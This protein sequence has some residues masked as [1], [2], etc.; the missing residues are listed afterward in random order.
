M[1]K[2]I[3][4]L[5]IVLCFAVSTQA[6]TIRYD[7]LDIIAHS[8]LALCQDSVC[9][10]VAQRINTWLLTAGLS[11]RQTSLT[12]AQWVK[13]RQAVIGTG[14]FSGMS[15]LSAMHWCTTD[16]D[17]SDDTTC[18]FDHADYLTTGY[19]CTATQCESCNGGDGITTT[20]TGSAYAENCGFYTKG[21][22]E[23]SN[24]LTKKGF[25]GGYILT[26]LGL[27][28]MLLTTSGKYY[29]SVGTAGVIQAVKNY[30]THLKNQGKVVIWECMYPV[31]VTA[32]EVA[33]VTL[34]EAI[35]PWAK[36]QGMF[37]I[38]THAHIQGTYSWS[39]WTTIYLSDSDFIHLNT[40][41]AAIVA[42]YIE[43]EFVKIL[44]V[45]TK[46]Y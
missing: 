11:V 34:S 27:K 13:E 3:I 38:D 4:T 5:I 12:D 2:I 32:T 28:D 9:D 15:V 17:D 43:Q 23:Y 45:G 6:G 10:P 14:G 19:T 30:L 42:T 46:M 21:C 40:A 25:Y 35:K 7:T 8:S 20:N 36:S 37:V 29:E 41:G 26:P 39:N 24:A 1:K 31:D 33:S 18:F 22:V 16:C 44:N